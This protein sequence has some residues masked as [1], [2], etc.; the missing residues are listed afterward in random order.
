MKSTVSVK[1]IVIDFIYISEQLRKLFDDQKQFK[2]IVDFI[3]AKDY[4]DDDLDLP[5]PK[6]KDL[7]EGTGIKPYILRKLL[8]QMHCQIFNYDSQL[9][10]RFKK[11]LYHFYIKFF[12]KYCYFTID[13]LDHLPRIGEQISL[14]FVKASMD[15]DWFYVDGIKHEFTGTTQNIYLTLKVGEFNSYWR[16]RKDQALELNEIGRNDIYNSKDD[17][18]LK[19]KVYFKNNHWNK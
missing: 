13:K 14:P 10:L 2:P 6:L 19:D 7:E 4:L 1:H 11:T 15:I 12:D 3:L 9:R 17:C 8:L 18:V 5:F 16:F